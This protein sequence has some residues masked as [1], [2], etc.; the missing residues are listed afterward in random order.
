[1]KTK[2]IMAGREGEFVR[3]L[4]EDERGRTALKYGHGIGAPTTAQTWNHRNA[5]A[6]TIRM[7]E[8]RSPQAA[9][10]PCVP[11]TDREGY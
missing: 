2:T 7:M 1:M 9:W 5:M 6:R 10:R 11:L 3:S 8:S 4:S